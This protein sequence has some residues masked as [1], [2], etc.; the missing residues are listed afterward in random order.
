[1]GTSRWKCGGGGGQDKQQTIQPI[2]KPLEQQLI[3]LLRK[4]TKEQ[5]SRGWHISEFTLRL[6]GTFAEHPHPQMVAEILIR[7]NWQNRRVYNTALDIN[8]ERLWFAPS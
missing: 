1:M 7:L 8:G 4:L 3:E 2:V 6:K 5:L